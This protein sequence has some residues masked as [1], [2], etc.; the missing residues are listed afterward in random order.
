[1]K[2]TRVLR[3]KAPE[4]SLL[5]R[6]SLMIR[7]SPLYVCP[8]HRPDLEPYSLIVSVVRHAG[9]SVGDSGCESV[10]EPDEQF[11]AI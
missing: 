3:V 1:M 9:N 10:M 7:V 4:K 6:S 5:V 8:N 11:A 2:A